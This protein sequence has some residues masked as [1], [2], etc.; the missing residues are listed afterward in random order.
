LSVY[1]VHQDGSTEP[2]L[3]VNTKDEIKELQLVLELNPALIPGEQIQPEDPC[4]WLIVKREMEVPDSLS[5]SN[6]WSVDFLF[7]DHNAIP[8]FVE[9][10]RY[11]DTRARREV[12][13]QVLEYVANAKSNWPANKLRELAQVTATKN[14][15]DLELEVRKL[16]G[17]GFKSVDAFF[18][19]AEESLNKS[20][21][22]IV[23]FLEQAPEELKRL[24]EFLNSQMID[25][26]VL[27]VEARLHENGALRVVSPRVYGFTEQARKTKQLSASSGNRQP[28]ATDWDSFARNAS[29]KGL[30]ADDIATLKRVFDESCRLS[31]EIAWG[32]GVST[33]S[34][35]PKWAAVSQNASPFS[36]YANGKLE[37]HFPSMLL[38]QSGASFARSWADALARSGIRLPQDALKTW[39]SYELSEWS[40]AAEVFLTA[41]REALPKL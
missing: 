6:R 18:A 40:P 3:E 13:G 8:T 39:Y 16:Q 36:I 9:C 20:E 5:G 7:L 31:A 2:M 33:G 25:T 27:L 21:V 24:V 41:L 10:K 29:A 37:M 30:S 19:T 17:A 12:I 14:G 26:E 11:K 22:R 38:S 35:S 32:R 15:K 4:R 1:I 23:F 28:I 34:F